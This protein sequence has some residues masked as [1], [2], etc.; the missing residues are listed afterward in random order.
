MMYLE[1]IPSCLSTLQ[2]TSQWAMSTFPCISGIN[3]PDIMRVDN[4]SYT[5]AMALAQQPIPAIPH[6][7]ANDFLADDLVALCQ[8][9]QAA[10]ITKILIIS[11]DPASDGDPNRHMDLATLNRL[12]TTLPTVQFYAGFDPYRQRLTDE[13]AYAKAKIDA[14]VVGLF[15]QP[16]FDLNLTRFLLKLDMKTEWH[17]GISP[18]L[19]PA[20]YRYWTQRNHVVFPADFEP[21]LAHNITIGRAIIDE[22][23]SH[24]YHNYIMPIKTD[25]VPYL[26]ALLD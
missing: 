3:I 9:L 11:G 2:H 5:A 15:T 25:I 17:I 12:C 20:S 23:H 21:T 18:I 10:G 1:L 7:R 6:I 13:Y 19:T 26:H 24:G 4:R 16:L 14:G 22:C 8:Q